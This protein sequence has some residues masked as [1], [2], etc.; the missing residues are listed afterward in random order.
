MSNESKVV[1]YIRA[2][3]IEFF[4]DHLKPYKPAHFFFDSTL[5]DKFVQKAS[6]IKIKSNV[7]INTLSFVPGEGLYCPST[8]GYSTVIAASPST[9][10]VNDNYT[11]LSVTPYG[12]DSN[13][14]TNEFLVDDIVFAS[15]NGSSDPSANVFMGRVK[16]FDVSN[17]TLIVETIGGTP[18]PNNANNTIF[19]LRDVGNRAN[20]TSV[21]PSG[22]NKFAADALV[23]ST[24]DNTKTFSVLEYTHNH[25]TIPVRSTGTS[26]TLGSVPGVVN[27][28]GNTIY[29]TSGSGITE[30]RTIQTVAG[31]SNSVITVDSAI[32]VTGNTTYSFG[33]VGGNYGPV[34]DEYGIIAGI[35]QLPET[36]ENKF[37]IGSRVFTITD[38]T[39]EHGIDNQMKSTAEFLAF[40][41]I[42][43]VDK[44]TPVVQKNPVAILPSRFSQPQVRSKDPVAQTF[45]TPDPSSD[46]TNYGIFVS[47]IDL[48]FKSKP[49]TGNL[50]PALP[51]TLKIVKTANG[52]PT[53]EIVAIASVDCSSVNVAD[54][55]TTF[56]DSTDATTYTK[57]LF[58][59]PV[60]LLPSQQYAMVVITDSPSYDLWVAELGGTVINDSTNSNRRISEQPYVGSF[61]RSQNASTWTP[62]QNEDLMFVI[63]K[64]VFNTSSSP[65]LV[66]N[67]VSTTSNIGIHAMTLLS[68]D[69]SFNQANINYSFRSTL[70]GT[71]AT[72]SSAT[73][74][75]K[76]KTFNFSSDLKTSSQNVNRKRIIRS[77]NAN[78]MFINVTMSSSNPDISPAL[79][80]EKI[81]LVAEEY[82]INS[83]GISNNNISITNSGGSHANAANIVVTISPPQLSTGTQATANVLSGGLVSGSVLAINIINQ[84]SGYVE[85]PTIT[86]AEP[87]I[88][89]NAQAVITSE[90]GSSGGNALARYITKKIVLSDGFDAGDLRVYVDA[91]R[92]SGTD[93]VAYY[94]VLSAADYDSFDNKTWQRMYLE[95][96]TISPDTVTP[97][98]LVFR[99]AENSTSLSYTKNGVTYPLGGTFKYFS[100]KLVML[101]QDASVPPII[102]NM[103]AI[104]LPGG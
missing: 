5:V 47:S 63:N 90:D 53:D 97:I 72:E 24:D 65:T 100:I 3:E 49:D 57:F 18:E 42:N 38:T 99:P 27:G 103:R 95:N 7:G 43:A 45:Y 33:P 26:I 75:E 46:T 16:Y 21:L 55:V 81:S 50:E 92:P 66:F 30:S 13:F 2:N 89:T 68:D 87:A 23:F 76:D 84:G 79:N 14:V 36:D 80:M 69:I 61:F 35:F 17:T 83:G 12:V 19:N 41:T 8:G 4:A 39:D 60:Y 51:V 34:V 82:V 91:I 56:P 9:I 6:N 40:S 25:G 20:I 22:S 59:D 11:K 64:A 86:I 102:Q 15:P 94:K 70:E 44:V 52:F 32:T 78:S 37:K 67:A 29:F 93:I 58:D 54:G 88:A 96:N 62:F 48:F 101:A 77:G 10:Y 1:P 71:L 73:S 85:S 104:A 28:S 98:E 74:F 31:G